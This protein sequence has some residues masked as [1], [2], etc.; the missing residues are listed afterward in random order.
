M[1]SFSAQGLAYGYSGL[2]SWTRA[3]VADANWKRTGV[4]GDGVQRRIDGCERL[5]SHRINLL[6]HLRVFLGIQ[7]V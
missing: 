6:K 4:V 3:E 2:P 1:H 7:G 5:R